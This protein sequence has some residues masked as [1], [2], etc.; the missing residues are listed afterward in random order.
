M[1][2]CPTG[3]LALAGLPP[4]L[5]PVKGWGYQAEEWDYK[6]FWEDLSNRRYPIRIRY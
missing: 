4:R 2:A 3:A 1:I 5:M 6:P